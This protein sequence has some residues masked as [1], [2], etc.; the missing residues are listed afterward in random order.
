MAS[1]RNA[2]ATHTFKIKLEQLGK[3]VV[4][5]VS[6]QLAVEAEK[7]AEVARSYAPV[8]E[9][10]LEEAIEVVKGGGGRNALGQ[11]ARNFYI[12]RVNGHAIGN[13][14]ERVGSYAWKMHQFLL[15]YG[16]GGFNL[17]SKSRDKR[18]SGNDVG[19]LFMTRALQD[20]KD[21][22]FK[23]CAEAVSSA[24]MGNVSVGASLVKTRRN[25]RG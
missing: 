12:V 17:G 2:K 21:A 5:G 14:G 4:R 18:R 13:G 10:K 9:H 7:V 6:S 20:T 1:S 24:L 19:G 23:N 22:I 3:N 8:D 15:P 25:T 11:F 16:E